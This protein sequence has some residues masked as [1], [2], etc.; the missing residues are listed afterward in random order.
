M[1]RGA[2][3]GTST[4]PTVSAVA[5]V[6]EA[7]AGGDAS[8]VPEWVMI[9]AEACDAQS[10][11]KI[12]K[13]LGYSPATLSQVLNGKYMGNLERVAEMVRG[14]LMSATVDCPINGETKLDTCLTDQKR[15]PPFA[16]GWRMQVYKAC[17]NGCPNFRGGK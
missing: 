7:W 5:S 8:R 12:A 1:K 4:K 17:R 10:R 11:G 15:T 9:L 2:A 14:A 13:R 16:S 3:A 6:I